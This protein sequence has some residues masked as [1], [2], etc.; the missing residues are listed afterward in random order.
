[1]YCVCA[2][3]LPRWEAEWVRQS[4]GDTQVVAVL[5]DHVRFQGCVLPPARS[6]WAPSSC[7]PA[8]LF[9]AVSGPWH[10]RPVGSPAPGRCRCGR[11]VLGESSVAV[12]R[13]VGA[14]FSPSQVFRPHTGHWGWLI[15]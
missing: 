12:L 1:M 9:S 11:R 6:L 14:T 2:S 8:P 7:F 13:A 3:P 5:P 4:L 15:R 10:P